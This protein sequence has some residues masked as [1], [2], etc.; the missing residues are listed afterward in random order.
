MSHCHHFFKYIKAVVKTFVLPAQRL[1]TL[2]FSTDYHTESDHFK[3]L[4]WIHVWAN[5]H[6]LNVCHFSAQIIIFKYL[7]SQSWYLQSDSSPLY[8]KDISGKYMLLYS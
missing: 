5:V 1:L 6:Y 7:I 3:V 8:F 4:Q 2:Y